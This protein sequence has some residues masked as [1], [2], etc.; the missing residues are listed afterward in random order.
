MLRANLEQ[1]LDEY[2]GVAGFLEEDLTKE[3]KRASKLVSAWIE[4]IFGH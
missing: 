4:I 2:E 3:A 1:K